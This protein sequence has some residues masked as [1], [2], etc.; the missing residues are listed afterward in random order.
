MANKTVVVKDLDKFQEAIIKAGYSYR[1][2]GREAGCS[3]TQISNIPNGERI[4]SA[5]TAVN[6]CKALKMTFDELF[7]I[8]N[9]YKS[10]QNKGE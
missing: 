6:I 10:N 1:G 3:Q 2:L 7:F 9:A 5:E 8:N 4:P